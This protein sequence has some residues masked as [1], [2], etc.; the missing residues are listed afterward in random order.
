MSTPDYEKTI[1]DCDEALKIDPE[2]IKVLNRRASTFETIG[3][4]KDALNG[5]LQST[6]T[7][8]VNCHTKSSCFSFRPYYYLTV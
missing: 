8:L 2:Y 4:Y 3:K 5:K 7:S 6:F 1:A